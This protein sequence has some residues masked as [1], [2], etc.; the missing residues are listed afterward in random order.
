MF[1]S[2]RLGARLLLAFA[3]LV[4]MGALV[5]AFGIHGLMSLND[6]NDSLYEKEL[7]GISY[8]K[9]ANINLIY[10][11]RA[12]GQFALATSDAER[13]AARETFK[14][15]VDTMRMWLDKSRPLFHSA[16]GQEQFDKLEGMIKVW[17]PAADAYLAAA[18]GKPL[19]AAD[20]ELA[21]LDLA[22]KQSNKVVDDQLT[23]LTK[24]KEENGATASKEGTE[25]FRF[26]SL[27]MGVLTAASAIGGVVIGMLITRGITRALGGEPGDVATVANAVAAGN[28]TTHIDTS[29]A[30]PGSVVAAMDHMQQSLR[31]VVSQV[32]ASSDSIAT[33]SSQIATGN[34]D[35]SQRTEEQASNLQ[36]TAASMEQLTATVKTNADTARQATQLAGSATAAAGQG[37][38]VVGQVV[39]TMEG[40]TASSKK[41]ADIIGVID[42]IAFQTNILALNAAVEAA[43]AGEQGRGFAV[44]ASE[45]RT[46]A[47]RS[48]A[49][50]K[51]IKGL[52]TESVEKVEAGSQQVGEAGRAMDDIVTQVQRVSDLIGEIGSATHEQTQGISQIGTAVSQLDQ[53]TQQNA[54]LVEESAAAA[55]SLSQQAARL[56]EAVGIFT[57]DTAQRSQGSPAAAA[58]RAAVA[59]PAKPQT[60]RK[61]AAAP[62]PAPA[63][64]AQEEWA[65]F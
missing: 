16:Q 56:V 48:A 3:S 43:R 28:L 44:V 65:S 49:A 59:R 22:V 15:S 21:K 1:K 63:A 5:A 60:A 33:G 51:E 7:L 9:E 64:H 37:G 62:A 36:Q 24:L 50:A 4:V 12:R 25:L 27:V 39:R 18:S 61:P 32:R 19:L 11:A 40:I 20:A 52:I 26:V 42:G 6:V 46:L 35:L 14:E 58:P 41:I 2:L 29:R 13:R 17:L 23:V 53:V 54:A 34:A 47:Q 8:V 45:V 57:L 30:A 10:A 38:V 55:D 31:K